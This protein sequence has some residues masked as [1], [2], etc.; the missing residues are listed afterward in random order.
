MEEKSLGK[1]LIVDD[2]EDLL[3]AAKMLLKKYA[4]EVTIEKD[5]RRIPFL[6]NNNSYDVILLDMNFTE[7]TTSG[8]EGFHWLKQ[9]KE[10]DPKSVVI[11]I[12][13]FGD[14]E[15]A[16]QALKEGATDFIL[17]PWQN[18]KLLATL[19]AASRLK[20]SYNQVDSIS[21]KSKQLQADLKKPFSEIIGQ[22]AAMKNIFSIIDKVAQTDANVLILGE[23]GT[24]KELIARAIHDRSLRN[25]EIFVG[26]DMGAITETLFESELFGHKRGAFTD[27]KEDR[28]GRFEVAD[29]GTLFLDEIGNLSMPL[30][31]KLLTALQKREVTRIGTNKSIPVDI[32]LISATNMKVHDMVMENSFRQDLLY[33]INTVE[34]FLPPLRDRQDDIPLLANHFLKVYAKKYRKEFSG[35]KPAA[36][37]LLQHYSWPGNIRELQHAIERAIIMAEGNELD[38]RDFFF[39]SSKPIAEKVSNNT[40]LNLDEVEKNVIQKAI[41]KNGG[42]ISKAAKE[43]GLTR[44]SLY[45]RLEKYGL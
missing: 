31:S 17:K 41:D 42:N 23:N 35:F 34:I 22:S 39:L 12:T 33:R 43:L 38:S 40:S 19:T 13:A 27:A 32:R 45:R 3:F 6:V 9:I 26:V 4:K 37:Q 5:P 44:A 28:A 30:Q 29:K 36:I 1:I 8:K 25:D 24:G 14:V 10:I 2:N 18:E 11:L 21:R 20:E 7:D 16:V 15:M